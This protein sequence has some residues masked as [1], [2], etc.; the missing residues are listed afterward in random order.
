M[1]AYLSKKDKRF[2]IMVVL[3]SVF[4]YIACGFW[5]R[6]KGARVVIKVDGNIQGI[7]SLE[8]DREIS[9]DHGKNIVEIKD[10]KAFMKKADCPDQ[11]CTHQKAIRGIHQTIVCLPNK[12]VIE[13]EGDEKSDPKNGI[14]SVAE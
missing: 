12:V 7:Y 11:I 4:L 6:E 5:S 1:E 13:I 9:V 14:D 3:L 10:K 8:E 2:V